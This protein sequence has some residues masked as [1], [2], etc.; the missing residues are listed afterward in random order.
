MFTRPGKTPIDDMYHSMKVIEKG[1]I[2]QR[3]LD[4]WSC[5]TTECCILTTSMVTGGIIG[6]IC[7][8]LPRYY[9]WHWVGMC[10]RAYIFPLENIFVRFKFVHNRTNLLKVTNKVFSF[11]L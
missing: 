4:C 8:G 5:E 2:A 10:R 7:I 9:N 11:S 6:A 1:T 3:E